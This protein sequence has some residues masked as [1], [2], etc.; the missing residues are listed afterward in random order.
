LLVKRG[1]TR[2][3]SPAQSASMHTAHVGASRSDVALSNWNP[4]PGSAD[5]DLLPD[6][7]LLTS[8]SRDLARNNGIAAGAGQTFKDNIVGSVLRLV[9]VPD[10]R[11]LG[12]T[13]ERAREWANVTEPQFRS[14]ADTTDC[15]AAGEQD[16]LGLTL[17]ALG[18]TFGNGDALAL[19]LW[20]PDPLSQWSTRLS[21]IESDRLS[22]PPQLEHREDIRGGIEKDFY[23][24]PVAYHVRR[25]HPGDAMARDRFIVTGL[26][27]WDRIPATTEWGRRRVIHLHDKERTGQSRGKPIVSA[28]MKEFHM[29][30]KYQSTE[31]E[32]A[33]SNA[34]VAA[35]LESNLD[36]ESA[37]TLFGENPR[38]AWGASVKQAQNLRQMRGAAI[39]PLPAGAKITP[40]SPGRPNAA[41]EAFMIASL[42]NIA[43]GMNMP[44]EL[45]LK[46]FSKTNYSSARAALLEAWRYFMGRRA[47]LIRVWLRPVYELWL[48]E[49]V[50]AGRIDA[51]DYYEKRYAYSRCRFIFSGRGWIDPVKE[52]EAAGIR[53]RLGISTLEAEC[54]EQGLDWEE[55]LEQQ[56]AERALR[57]RLGLPLD[58]PSASGAPAP[59]AVQRAPQ[60]NEERD[61]EREDVAA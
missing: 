13:P 21:L 18:G 10:Y 58:I 23:G 60:N 44:Y 9:A 57:Q 35:F 55:V 24:R 48:E 4:F 39:I 59:S 15:D 40:F 42:R 61:E 12:W 3:K 5:S 52:A 14:W 41:F 17:S 30:G 37:Q 28:V 45:L 27:D 43:A 36:Q 26:N 47:W 16:L 38:E 8:R 56:A 34:L 20:L 6:L 7:E 11:L 51:P 19:P 46:D 32:A 53:M 31:L 50:N 33:V 2:V 25:R 22:T 49:A 29:A 1:R 54:A